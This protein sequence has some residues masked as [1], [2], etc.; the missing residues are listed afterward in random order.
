MTVWIWLVAPFIG[1]I[2]GL[3]GA[4]GGMLT[5]PLLAYGVG[6]PFKEAIATSLWIVA[7]ASLIAV[8]QQRAWKILRPG[9]LIFFGIGGV[10]GGIGGAWVGSW[11]PV[12][13]QQAMFALLLLLVAWWMLRVKLSDDYVEKPC[14][15]ALALLIGIGHGLLTGLLGV[16]GGF[17]MVPSLLLLGISHLPTA[18]AH[19]LVM[20]AVNATVS[21]SVYLKTTQISFKLVIVTSLLAGFGSLAGNYFLQRL[22]KERLQRG[23]STGLLVLGLAMFVQVLIERFNLFH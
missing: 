8:T 22:S 20:I 13:I 23:F 9:M 17:L 7:V 16:G 14:H 3:F 6:L 12:W 5:V 2:L 18:I 1:L 4:G 11:L 15:C 19:S 21:G 10:T